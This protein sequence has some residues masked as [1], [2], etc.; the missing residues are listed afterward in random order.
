MNNGKGIQGDRG[1]FQKF[2]RIINSEIQMLKRFGI[3]VPRHCAECRHMERMGRVAPPR[4]WN[5]N[6][7]KCQAAIQTS[8]APDRPE[9]VYCERCYQAEVY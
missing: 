6:C 9:V 8:Y 3:P 1:R 2:Y 5:R 4:L 7:D